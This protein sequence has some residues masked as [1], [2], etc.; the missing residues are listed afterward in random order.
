M[1][2]LFKIKETFT[3]V[4]LCVS[5]ILSA[6][7]Q[8][9]ETIGG[10]QSN[11]NFG[12]SVAYSKTGNRM[13]ISDAVI[14]A[15]NNGKSFY[16]YEFVN[17]S[18]VQVGSTISLTGN[19]S[20]FTPIVGP[21]D[22]NDQGN[23][24]FI[25][26]SD[27]DGVNPSNNP[28]IVEVYEFN[29]TDWVQIGNSVIGQGSNL[30]GRSLSTNAL[31]NRMVIG[32]AGACQVYEYDGNNWIELG[33]LLSN[34]DTNFGRDVAMNAQGNKI[35]CT[36]FSEAIVYEYKENT[37]TGDFEWTQLGPSISIEDNALSVAFN[38]EGNRLLVGNF[39]SNAF[40][41]EVSVYEFSNNDWNLLGNVLTGST[42]FEFFGYSVTMNDIGNIIA[43]SSLDTDIVEIFEY[44][45]NSNSWLQKTNPV[46]VALSIN[47]QPYTIALDGSGLNLI[48]AAF[49]ESH[50]G[51]E[52]AGIVKTFFLQD[53]LQL[54]IKAI[55][56]GGYEESTTLMRGNLRVSGILPLATP[57]SDDVTTT[58]AIFD[59][60]GNDAI[61]DWVFVELRDK[62]DINQVIA[63]QSALLQ[64]DGD[65]V[66]SDGISPIEIPFI[67]TD[68]FY[69]SISHR[70]HIPIVLD[71][72]ILISEDSVLSLDFSNDPTLL[73][74]G[75]NA[76][77]EISSGVYGLFAGDV[78]K[79][80]NILTTDYSQ[81]IG[82]LNVSGYSNYDVD[83]NGTVLTT[84]LNLVI[85][86]SLNAGKQF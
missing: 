21:V 80:G 30:V 57:Y 48:A 49:G 65:I 1:N 13:L 74:G 35:V 71:A 43:I 5:F 58:Q 83:M 77:K 56:S 28:G 36:D 73:R 41:G 66:A 29:G 16:V 12:I 62:N 25:G 33:N 47:N 24:I 60:E 81:T 59:V 46:D 32:R 37:N 82:Q 53:P 42:A 52:R 27:H 23:R 79:D 9:G 2:N 75:I 61:V 11:Q 10:T 54:S 86:R 38:S 63:S 20:S 44:D 51:F 14:P 4:F 68:N 45:S 8:R 26:D 40:E 72:P 3:I 78:N 76:V 67:E 70:N 22:M 7:I 50:E 84:D 18:W 39:A 15:S 55:L 85:I 6:Q 34:G 17:N 69:V 31:G 19:N 64:R